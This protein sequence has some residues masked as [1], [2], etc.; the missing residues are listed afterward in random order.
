MKI[1]PLSKNSYQTFPLVDSN[2]K[3]FIGVIEISEEDYQ[4]LQNRSSCF[5]PT[6]TAVVDYYETE[7]EKTAAIQIKLN[8]LRSKRQII[9]E[10]FDKYKINV[11]YGIAQESDETKSKILK[12]YQNILDLNESAF[13]N[14]PEVIQYYLPT[15][16]TSDENLI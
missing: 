10:A 5:N 15:N 3:E 2:N 9:L 1:L 7:E 13:T 12:W 14:I 6:L 4:K 16:F 8:Q 11:Y